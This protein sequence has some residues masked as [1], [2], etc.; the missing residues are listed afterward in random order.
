MIILTI[1]NTPSGLVQKQRG[2][3][4]GTQKQRQQQDM[5][6]AWAEDTYKHAYV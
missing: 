5:Q 3:N 1:E 6:Q 4:S 2:S